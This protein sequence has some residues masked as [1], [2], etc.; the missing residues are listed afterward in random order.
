MSNEKALAI[1]LKCS[2]DKLEHIKLEKGSNDP[3]K[4][5]LSLW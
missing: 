3:P 4:L 5:A 1:S 2:S